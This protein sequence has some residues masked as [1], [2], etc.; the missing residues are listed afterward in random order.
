MRCRF[1]QA[2]L[3]VAYLLSCH[4][5][6]HAQIVLPATNSPAQDVKVC[7]PSVVDKQPPSVPEVTIAELTFEGDLRMSTADQDQIATSLKQRKYS[8]EPDGVASEVFERVR[9]AWQDRGY[10]NVRVRGDAKVLSSSPVSERIGVAVQ[11]DEGQQYLLGGIRFRN[12]RAI[13]NEKFLRDLFPLKD[14]KIF[15]RK[16]IAKGLDNL[17]FAYRQLGYIT[18]LLFR[19]HE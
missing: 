7:A 3:A 15:S 14:G 16:E 8:G 4:T 1:A 19:I 11:V 9:A 18:L 13:S 10:F 12:I 17:R 5:Q 2:A 6:A